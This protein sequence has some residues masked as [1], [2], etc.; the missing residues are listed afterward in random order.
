MNADLYVNV[1]S[2][3]FWPTYPETTVVLPEDM[4]AD[5]ETFRQFYLAKQTGRKLMW[6]PALGHCVIKA[7]FPHVCG[8]HGRSDMQLT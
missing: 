4:S 8:L 6:R 5:L 3:A 2:Q 7:D 1:L